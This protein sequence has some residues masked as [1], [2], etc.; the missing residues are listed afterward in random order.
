MNTKYILLIGLLTA[1][2]TSCNSG[3]NQK[4]Q[5]NTSSTSPD[6]LTNLSAISA[7]LPNTIDSN[8]LAPIQTSTSPTVVQPQN[9]QLNNPT[10]KTN[11]G[12][13]PAHGQPGHRCDISVGAPLSTASTTG[14]TTSIPSNTSPSIIQAQN[15]VSNNAQLQQSALN[16][17]TTV[18]LNPAHGQ[19]GHRCD[20]SVGAPLD[21]KPTSVTTPPVNSTIPVNSTENVNSSTSSPAPLQVNSTLPIQNS[22]FKVSLPQPTTSSQNANVRVNPAHGQPGHDCAVP[23]GKPLKQ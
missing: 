8:A 19:P 11:A 7:G 5:Q 22:L 1:T 18:G 4:E 23:V 6:S 15:P 20:I 10:L 3:I 21:S 16:P 2:I 12:L 13:N 14:T 17:K 9:P